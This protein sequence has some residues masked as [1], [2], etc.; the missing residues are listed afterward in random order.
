MNYHIVCKIFQQTYHE[1]TKNKIKYL[2]KMNFLKLM[3]KLEDITCNYIEECEEY[4][5]TCNM[6]LKNPLIIIKDSNEDIVDVI[7]LKE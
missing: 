1:S 2:I 7:N 5:V 4:N 3:N 6:V